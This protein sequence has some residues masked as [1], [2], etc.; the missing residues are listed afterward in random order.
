MGGQGAG[1]VSDEGSHV[2]RPWMHGVASWVLL[3]P[4]ARKKV[5]FSGNGELSHKKT[6]WLLDPDLAS[7]PQQCGSPP[8][9]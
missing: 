6:E 7:Q 8:V 3:G 4:L 2:C 9:G 1:R 5:S